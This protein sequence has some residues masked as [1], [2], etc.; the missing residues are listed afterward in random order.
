[1]S[2]TFQDL[3][4]VY[5]NGKMVEDKEIFVLRE[6]TIITI[7]RI[8]NALLITYYPRL[9]LKTERVVIPLLPLTKIVID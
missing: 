3:H 9:T 2:K 1:M 8:E 5:S 4:F 7:E 6:I